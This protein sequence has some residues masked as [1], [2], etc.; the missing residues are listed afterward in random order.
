MKTIH[1]IGIA[2]LIILLASFF[3]LGITGVRTVIGMF[4]IFVLPAYLLLDLTSLDSEEK[5]F[6]GT[7]LGI[8]LFALAV[9]FVDRIVPSMRISTVV[10]YVIVV[11]VWYF[12]RGKL[13]KRSKHSKEVVQDKPQH[14][15][16][17][18]TN[19]GNT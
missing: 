7:T 19:Q 13:K 2:T 9:F 6:I 18:Q 12:G 14:S 3:I 10:V 17:H 16:E 4:L 15:T 8:S 5:F 11:L 1:L